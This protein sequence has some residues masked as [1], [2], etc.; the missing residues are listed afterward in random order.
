MRDRF[1]QQ[2][3]WDRMGLPVK[4]SIELVKRAPERPLFEQMIFSKIVPNCR[5]LGLLDANRGWL[6]ERFTELG[7]IQF[8][9]FEDTG[10]EY[11]MFQLAEG[12]LELK[13]A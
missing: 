13:M 10:E 8:E 9:H 4:E 2:E 11:A 12:K 6:R 1:L 5:K 3:V 7:V